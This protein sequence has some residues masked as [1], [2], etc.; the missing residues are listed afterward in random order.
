M[1]TQQSF[2]LPEHTNIIIDTYQVK[3]AGHEND[4][5]QVGVVMKKTLDFSPHGL[6]CV[7]VYEYNTVAWQH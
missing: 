7:G 4:P 5:Q 1:L 3:V 2:L 6:T